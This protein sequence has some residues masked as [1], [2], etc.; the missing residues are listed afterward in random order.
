MPPLARHLVEYVSRWG[1]NDGE[2]LPERRAAFDLLAH[3]CREIARERDPFWLPFPSS[4]ALRSL[5]D[6]LLEDPAGAPSI[7]GAA[8]AAAMSARTFS[9][10]LAR[11]CGMTW[12]EIVHRARMTRATELLAVPGAK[13]SAVAQDVGFSSQ[14]AFIAAFRKFSGDTP[15]E[16]RRRVTPRTGR[17]E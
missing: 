2:E 17:S 16:F 8:R 14:P 7:L 4:P 6:S 9:R 5:F 15:S 1:A 12:R 11:E 3:V 10:V 13:M